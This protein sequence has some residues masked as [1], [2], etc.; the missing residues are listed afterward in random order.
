MEYLGLL[1]SQDVYQYFKEKGLKTLIRFT[2][3]DNIMVLIGYQ[4]IKPDVVLGLLAIQMENSS[5][6]ETFEVF[7]M[8]FLQKESISEL[9]DYACSFAEGIIKYN[10]DILRYY[11]RM[12]W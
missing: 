10:K 2:Q 6:Y 9:E 11:N 7:D 1:S 4:Y 12:K 8:S 3:I 5:T